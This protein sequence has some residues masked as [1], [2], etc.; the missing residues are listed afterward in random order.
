MPLSFAQPGQTGVIRRI[1][2]RDEARRHL[3]NLG[4]VAGEQVTVISELNGSLILRLRDGRVALD[5][6]LAAR[7]LVA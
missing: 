7:I 3:E 5:R 1:T 2:G 6:A 4:F